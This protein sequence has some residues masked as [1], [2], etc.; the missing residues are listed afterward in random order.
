MLTQPYAAISPTAAAAGTGNII[1][2]TGLVDGPVC[3]VAISNAAT[4]NFQQT[5]T[6]DDANSWV[7]CMTTTT[8]GAFELDPRGVFYR[9]T[10]SGNNGNLSA[11][12]G[13]GR[14]ASEELAQVGTRM[15]R[16]VAPA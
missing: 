10:W 15:Q 11:W 2:A 4:V 12:V 14:G 3:S 16:T 8:S 6:P 9:L 1:E 7:T 13:P 5:F